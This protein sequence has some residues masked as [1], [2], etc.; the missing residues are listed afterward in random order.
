[1]KTSLVLVHFAKKKNEWQLKI[2]FVISVEPWRL[3][4]VTKYA[5]YIHGRSDL[6]ICVFD[7]R[8]ILIEWTGLRHEACGLHWVLQFI[9]YSHPAA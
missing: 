2:G 1:M 3:L 6:S 8:D 7:F 4:F 9:L 5:Q